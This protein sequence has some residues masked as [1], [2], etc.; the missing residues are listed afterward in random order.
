M[1]AMHVHTHTHTRNKTGGGLVIVTPPFLS[2]V[3][4]TAGI[5]NHCVPCT[6]SFLQQTPALVVALAV[7]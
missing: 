3:T 5:Y 4:V 7:G 6:V 1:S 2:L